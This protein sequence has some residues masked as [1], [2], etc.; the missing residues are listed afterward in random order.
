MRS[1][2]FVLMFAAQSLL[3]FGADPA[4]PQQDIKN[5]F[6]GYLEAFNSGD[7]E[8]LSA[9]WAVGA[10]ALNESTG[11]RTVGR[12]AIA[13]GLRTLFAATPDARLTGTVDS[14]RALRPDVAIAEGKVTLY[15]PGAEPAPSAF[16]AVL[17]KEGGEWVFESSQERDL[18]APATPADALGELAWLVGDWRDDTD[19]VD[20]QSTVRWSANK[21]FLIRSFRADFDDGASFE[22]TQVFGWD[23]RTKQYRTW[24]FNSDGSFGEG[25]VSLN[26]D[27]TLIKMSH[28]QSDGEVSAGVLVLTRVDNDTMRVEKIGQSVGGA[29]VPQG[30]PVTVVRVE[31][32]SP[33]ASDAT[34]DGGAH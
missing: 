1:S 28:V 15:I 29:P 5:R 4:V 12:E 10:T 13:E 18:P 25:D 6:A 21:A 20:A 26:G 7:V 33:D 23:P 3:C 19:G 31:S 22:G 17:T 32:V 16:T 27:D 14:V 8:R 30:E 11:E 9:C 2:L 34:S 24:T